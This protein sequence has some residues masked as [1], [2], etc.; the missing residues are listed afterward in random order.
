MP[1]L[2]VEHLDKTYP[3]HVPVRALIDV[4]LT[5]EQ[6]EYV[7]IE[8]PSGSGKSTLLN[9][10]ALLDQ[11]TR[12]EY[13]IDG[14]A[15]SESDDAARAR[16]RSATFAFIFQS[17]HLL[18]GRSVV[19]NV[20][21]G[22]LYRGLPFARRREL[23]REA[24]EFVGL[25]DR[26]DERAE[27]L[28]GGQRQRVAIAR[29]IASG[30][31]VVVA[32]EPTGNLDQ[33]SGAVVMDT[34]ERLNSQG[35]TVIVVTHDP[36]VSVRARRRL[37]VLDGHV[38]D[39][40]STSSSTTDGARGVSETSRGGD[41][42]ANN[43]AGTCTAPPPTSDSGLVPPACA[44]APEGCD[45]KV[46]FQDAIGDAWRGMWVRPSRTLGLIAAVAVGV[47][48]ALTTAGLSQTASSQVSAIF[49]AQRNQR[50]AMTSP[51]LSAGTATADQAASGESLDRVLA[52]VGVEEAAVFL[53]HSSVTIA[54]TPQGTSSQD[55]QQNPD[56]VGLVDGHLPKGVFVVDTQG[57]ALTRLEKGEVLV[58][59]QVAQD[60]QL[61]PLLASPVVWVDGVPKKVAGVLDDAGLQVNLLT[62]VIVPEE[63]ASLTSTA[64]YASAE[65]KVLPGAAAQVASQA[66]A[67]W[68]PADQGSVTVDAPP[69][70]TGLRDQ[71]ESSVQVML[72]TLTGVALF[73]AVV[74]LTNAM[75]SAVFQRTGEFGLRRAMGARRIHVTSLV[76]SESLAVGLLGGFTGAYVSVLAIL[77][78]TIA[79]H[80]QP[81]LDPVFIPT[82]IVG[83]VL[84]GILG[85]LIAT[86]RASRIQPS[87]A[88]RT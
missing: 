20:A 6:G 49:D 77:G 23:A 8:G 15:T 17:F 61:G 79:R 63:D 38:E 3:G 68:I 58:G 22:T 50:V 18:D 36:Q 13:L 41:A 12:G 84:I 57:Q 70:P 65:I 27:N 54:T 74:S 2:T 4:C 69:D 64:N 19:D 42:V 73:A 60:I 39:V 34:L 82:G 45:S 67:A 52:L 48:L 35:A 55:Q 44:P 10:L 59:A 28:S 29:A 5:V 31:P 32:D 16:L 72:L 11:P 21:L 47:G 40:T 26:S 62:S 87:D 66:P 33:A 9:E 78:V 53:T 7:A 37:R 51:S 56:L 88:L 1:V 75:T 14:V 85:G 86:R 76:L 81:V 30:A 46:R 24:L 80:W 71:I 43:R 83:G 25:A